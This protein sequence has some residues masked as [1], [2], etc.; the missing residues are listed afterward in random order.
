MSEDS[1][2]ARIELLEKEINLLVAKQAKL[3]MLGVTGKAFDR[4]EYDAG[5]ARLSGLKTELIAAKDLL[6]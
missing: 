3:Y 4:A 1:L 5:E 2:Y 6:S